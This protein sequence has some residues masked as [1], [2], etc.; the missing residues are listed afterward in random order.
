MAK[1]AGENVK[2]KWTL[3]VIDQAS[4]DV[5]R[6][7]RW[8]LALKYQTSAT[9]I[10]EMVTPNLPIPDN[11]TRGI[12]SDID[13][14][15]NGNLQNIVVE[16]DI[17]HSYIGDLRVDLVS[18][19]G[20]LVRLHNKEGGT[21]NHIKRSYDADT[22]PDLNDLLDQTLQGRWQLRVRDYAAWDVGTL[23]SWS[24]TLEF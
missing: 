16:V 23:V 19:S 14:T 3:V 1:L 7:V 20:Q 12:S 8:G 2:G 11:N 6:L 24:I 5:G 18:P 15:Q 22:T 9:S 10:T 21:K 17:S 13:I 4:Q